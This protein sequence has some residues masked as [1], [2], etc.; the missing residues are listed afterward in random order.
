MISINWNWNFHRCLSIENHS[1][2]RILLHPLVCAT[3]FLSVF[4]PVSEQHYICVCLH[5]K[6]TEMFHFP[7]FWSAG[8][9]RQR[10]QMYR[11]IGICTVFTSLQH[12]VPATF[13][14]NFRSK[15]ARWNRKCGPKN[16]V[17]DGF[18]LCLKNHYLNW[19]KKCLQL[20]VNISSCAWQIS[21]LD[22]SFCR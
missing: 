6:M 14:H 13:F 5:C 8:A 3:L 18:E 22:I 19:E 15:M 4:C 1:T 21:K 7:Q 11:F 9:C 16:F 17:W 12:F 20:I 2:R 10:C